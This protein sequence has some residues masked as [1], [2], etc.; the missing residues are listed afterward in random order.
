MTPPADPRISAFRTLSTLDLDRQVGSDGATWL[1]RELVAKDH[2]P[3]AG[4]GFGQEVNAALDRRA[5][6]LVEMGH[7]SVKDGFISFP[8]ARSPRWSARRSSESA[9]RWPPSV[10]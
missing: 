9:K 3:L 7:A 6:R 2:L 8:G 5:A 4:T 1:D 10:D